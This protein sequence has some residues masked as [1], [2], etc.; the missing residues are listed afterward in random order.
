MRKG[1]HIII[2]SNE[3]PEAPVPGDPDIAPVAEELSAALAE[4]SAERDNLAAEKSEL[5]ERLLRRQAEF[6]N[7]RRRA[8]R[9]RE[10][11]LEFAGAGTMEALLPVL[12]DF[13]RGLKAECADKEYARGMELI[14]QRLVDAAKKL[15]L[16][17]LQAEGAK[18]DPNLHHAVDRV[19]SEDAEDGTVLDELQRGY[20]Y[21]GR[22]LRPAMVRVTYK[23]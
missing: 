4:L 23:G 7:V 13:E 5:Q 21:R 3:A 10:E 19:P 8:Q 2:S 9:E 16:E 11:Y 20:N 12:D 14:Y 17:P 1:D 18:F 6:E 15:G 22:L